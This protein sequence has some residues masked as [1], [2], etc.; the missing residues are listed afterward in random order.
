[1]QNTQHKANQQQNETK[2]GIIP[3]KV[4][5]SSGHAP[6]SRIGRP[7]QLNKNISRPN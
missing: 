1:M 6:T 7:R 5:Y 2:W 4:Q 3:V